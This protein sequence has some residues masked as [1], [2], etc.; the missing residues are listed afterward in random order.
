MRQAPSLPASPSLGLPFGLCAS[1]LA[2]GLG[3][4]LSDSHD[5]DGPDPVAQPKPPKP[6]PEPEVLP[7]GTYQLT[8][9]IDLTVENVLPEPGAQLVA[10]LRDF[11]MNPAHTLI[12]LAD[13]AGVPAVAELR[14]ALPDALEVRL[15]GWLN[16]EIA[17]LQLNG[18]PLPVAAA[19]LTYYAETELTGVTLRSELALGDGRVTHR[20]KT[21]STFSGEVALG[22]LPDEVVSASAAM[23]ASPTL[24]TLDDHQFGIAY[25]EY[26]WTAIEQRSAALTGA[27]LRPAL[28]AAV[29]CPALAAKV[30]DKC[31]LGFCV[32]HAAELTQICERGLDEVVD[33][34]HAKVASI[35]FTALRFAAGSATPIVAASGLS[36]GEWTAEID[37]GMGLRRAPATFTGRH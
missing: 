33:R 31:F 6:E 30:A 9:Q 1:L 24:L 32:G 13:E 37:V 4:C 34:A 18:I 35:R 22:A 28:G 8:S 14:A 16:E 19:L 36:D 27:A 25:G 10:T 2:V 23:T 11:S 15:E 5:G 12:D 20:L 3:G 26:A 21:I 29:N 7:Y 17:K